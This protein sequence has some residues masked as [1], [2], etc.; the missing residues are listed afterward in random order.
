MVFWTV[1]LNGGTITD[2]LF[3]DKLLLRG[4]VG[5]CSWSGWRPTWPRGRQNVAV[6]YEHGYADGDVPRSIRMV[7][8]SIASR[9]VVQGPAQSETVGDVTVNYSVAASDLTP[10]ELR[11]LTKY[12]A[13][14]SF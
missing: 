3:T 12:R 14:Q 5:E 10:G 13:A 4:T 1:V 11:I 9:L 8:L 6:T 7:A 2:Y